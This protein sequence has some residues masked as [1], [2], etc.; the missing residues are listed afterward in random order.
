[1]MRDALERELN[2]IIN[3][4]E[5]EKYLVEE[6]DTL[7]RMSLEAKA[8]LEG[9]LQ[10]KNS[11]QAGIKD[12]DLDWTEKITKIKSRIKVFENDMTDIEQRL[13][14]AEGSDARYQ[15]LIHEKELL[16]SRI[17]PAAHKQLQ[18]IEQV[19]SEIDAQIEMLEESLRIGIKL[20][21]SLEG[22]LKPNSIKTA[23]QNDHLKFVLPKALSHFIESIKQIN[24]TL[25]TTVS[26]ESFEQ[27]LQIITTMQE[28]HLKDDVNQ[29]VMMFMWQLYEQSQTVWDEL[30]AYKQK[31][32]IQKMELMLK[33]QEII[34]EWE[35][36]Q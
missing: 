35:F 1:M 36:E 6:L 16:L 5:E 27:S 8:E 26:L 17:S 21:T 3:I 30:E 28:I 25:R 24:Q 11:P 29:E 32:I 34:E 31:L 15:Q 4:R 33:R 23:L 22:W 7:K 14:S 2:E 10:Q 12:D 13:H 20:G 19:F 18:A 9:L